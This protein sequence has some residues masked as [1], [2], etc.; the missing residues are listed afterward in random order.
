MAGEGAALTNKSSNHQFAIGLIFFNSGYLQQVS[1][2][3]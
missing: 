3:R 1:N 2:K